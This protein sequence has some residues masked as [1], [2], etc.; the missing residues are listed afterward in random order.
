MYRDTLINSQGCDSF[1]YLSLTVIDTTRKDSFLTICRYQPIV[2]NGITRN[3]SGVYRDTFVN[4]RGCDSFLV[5]N[6]TVNDSSRKDSFRTICVN[7]PIVFNGLNLN[8]TGVYRDTFVNARGCDSFLV[9]NLTVNDTSR[10]DSFRTISKGV[11]AFYTCI[12]LSAIRP[13][14]FFLIPHVKI[15]QNPLMEFS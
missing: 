14:H 3:T 5:L 13:I 4:A 7:K 9:L 10:K 12:Y 15:N 2:F 1:V 11:I 8:T 6:L